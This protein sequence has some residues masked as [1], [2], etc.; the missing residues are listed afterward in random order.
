MIPLEPMLG[1]LYTSQE[2]PG[3]VFWGFVLLKQ[4]TDTNN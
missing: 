3:G 4:V 1:F 2:R